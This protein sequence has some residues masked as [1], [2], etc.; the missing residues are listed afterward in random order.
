[1]G[2]LLVDS[3]GNDVFDSLNSPLESEHIVDEPD[4][5]RSFGSW[6]EPIDSADQV[7]D[8]F[9]NTN[10]FGMVSDSGGE[11]LSDAYDVS[12]DYDPTDPDGNG[13]RTLKIVVFAVLAMVVLYL[14]RPFVAAVAGVTG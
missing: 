7:L 11:F 3:E 13:G 4:L 8:D 6:A 2:N 10:P 12:K 14:V 5:S 9:A 1:M